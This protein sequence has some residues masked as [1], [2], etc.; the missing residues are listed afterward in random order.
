[1]Y[2]LVVKWPIYDQE[3][4]F[5]LGNV[6][7]LK[8]TFLLLTKAFQHSF[9]KCQH[10]ICIFSHSFTFKLFVSLKCLSRRH[11]LVGLFYFFFPILI[12]SAFYLVM[13]RPFTFNVTNDL[14]LFKSTLL[15]CIYLSLCSLF[16]FFLSAIFWI[17]YFSG[18]V[19]FSEFV[20]QLYLF[21]L[22]VASTLCS[23]LSNSITHVVYFHFSPFGLCTFIFL[24]SASSVL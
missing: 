2:V 15:L 10:G 3:V 12:I 23:L 14:V 19:L 18:S 8:S 21:V 17:D 20:Y 1:M 4:I 5:I 16:P 11:S 7:D 24:Y 6:F 9:D 13:I 22:E